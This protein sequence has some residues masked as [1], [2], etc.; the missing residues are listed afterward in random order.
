L[1]FEIPSELC[2]RCFI[3]FEVE[4][5][6]LPACSKKILKASNVKKSLN[7]VLKSDWR[8]TFIKQVLSLFGRPG[9]AVPFFLT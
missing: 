8:Q 3:R 5:T 2:V 7:F 4:D 6:T 1:A 9:G